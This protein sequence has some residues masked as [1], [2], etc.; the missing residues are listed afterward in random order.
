NGTACAKHAEHKGQ[1]PKNGHPKSKT[2]NHKET[3]KEPCQQKGTQNHPLCKQA[4]SYAIVLF[5]QIAPCQ[6]RRFMV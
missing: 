3:H 2:A 1:A 4:I 6:T 5:F